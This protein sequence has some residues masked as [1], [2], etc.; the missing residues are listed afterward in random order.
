M[1]AKQDMSLTSWMHTSW[2]AAIVEM[3]LAELSGGLSTAAW[4]V[5]KVLINVTTTSIHNKGCV[6]PEY[7]PCFALG[8]EGT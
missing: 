2:C 6:V 5:S 8:L 1:Q 4:K 7:R 3:L